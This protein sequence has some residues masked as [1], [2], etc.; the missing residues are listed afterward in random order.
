MAYGM[1][2]EVVHPV[3]CLCV[4]EKNN[5]QVISEEYTTMKKDTAASLKKPAEEWDPLSKST[6]AWAHRPTLPG[7]AGCATGKIESK[8]IEMDVYNLRI[9][10]N[11]FKCSTET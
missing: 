1:N 10:K 8:D 9:L 6:S 7:V 2:S 4:F 5:K 11:F 3:L